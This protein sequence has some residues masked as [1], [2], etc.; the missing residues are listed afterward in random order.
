VLV[1]EGGTDITKVK[2]KKRSPPM[3]GG[4]QRGTRKWGEK[5]KEFANVEKKRSEQLVRPK[6]KERTPDE[7]DLLGDSRN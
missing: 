6:G 2:K 7:D 3:M 1:K 5:A 4:D